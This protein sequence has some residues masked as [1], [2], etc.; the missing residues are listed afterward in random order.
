MMKQICIIFCVLALCS[1]ILSDFWKKAKRKKKWIVF[2]FVSMALV[3]ATIMHYN[4]MI[5]N[6]HIQVHEGYFVEEHRAHKGGWLL[7]E[8]VFTNDGKTKPVFKLDVKSKKKIY[9]NDFEKDVQYRIYYEE[10]TDII[11]RVEKIE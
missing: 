4:N 1:F 3:V 11:L 5:Q 10:R 6:P 9:P 7:T 8:Y 2:G